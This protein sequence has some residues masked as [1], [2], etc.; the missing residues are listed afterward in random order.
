MLAA[1]QPSQEPQ[2]TLRVS[3]WEGVFPNVIHTEHAFSPIRTTYGRQLHSSFAFRETGHNRHFSLY[4]VAV[5]LRKTF[6]VPQCLPDMFIAAL[7][8]SGRES[9]Q[10]MRRV[11]AIDPP[12]THHVWYNCPLLPFRILGVSP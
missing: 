3:V 10:R 9:W 1:F 11:F 12:L 5:Y 2:F 6:L 4:A 7:P 8:I